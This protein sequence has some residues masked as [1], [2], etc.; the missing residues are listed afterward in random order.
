MPCVVC[1]AEWSEQSRWTA[2]KGMEGQFTGWWCCKKCTDYAW[3]DAEREVRN[4]AAT[5]ETQAQE[6]KFREE[7]MRIF[8]LELLAAARCAPLGLRCN[9]NCVAFVSIMCEIIDMSFK[10]RRCGRWL[11]RD[12]GDE[13]L[14][15]VAM[16]RNHD[17]YCI[18]KHSLIHPVHIPY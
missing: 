13:R 14:V 2:V 5:V 16:Y 6:W 8:T 1:R 4:E 17:K 18:L 3:K 9:L 10:S 12:L 15:S 11:Q 7:R